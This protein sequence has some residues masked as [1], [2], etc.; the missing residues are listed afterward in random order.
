MITTQADYDQMVELYAPI[1]ERLKPQSPWFYT[2]KYPKDPQQY[3]IALL[4]E[5]PSKDDCTNGKLGASPAGLLLEVAL[6]F[7]NID[8]DICH[9]TNVFPF[10]K[11]KGRQWAVGEADHVA[12]HVRER[13][14]KFSVVV[15][16]GKAAVRVYDQTPSN[17]NDR[18][19]DVVVFDHPDGQEQKIVYS[20]AANYAV[21]GYID[22]SGDPGSF[23]YLVL[24][25]K[26]ALGVLKGENVFESTDNHKASMISD[27]SSMNDYLHSI[28]KGE[29]SA[30]DFEAT[31]TNPYLTSL[32]LC[33]G[34]SHD[35]INSTTIAF[36]PWYPQS[37]ITFND[38][39]N[40]VTKTDQFH[41]VMHNLLYDYS[42]MTRFGYKGR[43]PEVDSMYLAH[44]GYE[45]LPKSLKFLSSFFVKIRPYSFSFNAIK[46]FINGAQT[47]EET[48][49]LLIKLLK[50]C[51]LDAISTRLLI[52]H[53]PKIAGDEW[54]RIQEVYFNY[55]HKL[56]LALH[57]TQCDGLILNQDI[58]TTVRGDL[59]KTIKDSERNCKILLPGVDNVRSNKQLGKAFEPI[60]KPFPKLYKKNKTGIS[61][62]AD[63]L[64][65]LSEK[66][67]KAAAEL[68]A[69]RKATKLSTTYVEN[70]PQYLDA[71]GLIHTQFGLAKTS[72]LKSSDPALQTLPRKSVVL[73]LFSADHGL[74]PYDHIFIKADYSAAEA[75]LLAYYCGIE[76]LLDPTIDVHVLSATMFFGVSVEE[77]SPDMRQKTKNLTFGTI[78]GASAAR[79]AM[80]VFGI[81]TD[82]T[83]GK[84]QDLLDTFLLDKFPEIKQF[85]NNREADIGTQGF[86]EMPITHLRRHFPVECFASQLT[87]I[88]PNCD[89]A[90]LRFG[91]MIFAKAIREG[92]NYQPQS[93]V[94]YLTNKALINLRDNYKA[95]DWISEKP[96]VNLQFHDALIVRSHKDDFVKALHIMKDTMMQPIAGPTIPIDMQI[97]W[98]LKDCIEIVAANESV[99]PLDWVLMQN[100]IIDAASPSLNGVLEFIQ[101]SIQKANHAQ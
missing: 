66:G 56:L 73:T 17:I 67:I 21:K 84:A 60:V 95:L 80:L 82:E 72:R 4:G 11:P 31:S 74:P 46:P 22:P 100:K 33:V 88:D 44:A 71:N 68:L 38:Y 14:K 9:I 85:M 91:R 6:N 87:K 64:K 50:Y 61:L 86:I 41:I 18:S 1:Y 45:F 89:Q 8:I 92:Y 48:E 10:T 7:A 29:M 43:P 99:K 24:A 98:N 75:R 57:G 15:A 52:S 90:R 28:P 76:K 62:T 3:Q 27:K 59:N 32:P 51:G 78:Y 81:V 77:V 47:Y 19:G 96:S 70:Y 58:L 63:I 26:N 65:E 53:F 83:K 23:W 36:H 55:I 13:L 2:D 34:M 35:G 25:L 101:H 39:L 69:F 49:Y 20:V 93:G 12:L 30:V 40:T 54:D 79:V 5:A 97:G 37:N 16:M 42:L 94:A